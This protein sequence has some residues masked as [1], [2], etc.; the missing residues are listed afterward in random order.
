M[1]TVITLILCAF[2]GELVAQEVEKF[3]NYKWEECKPNEARFYSN[4]QKTDSGYVRKDYFI[5]EKMLQMS[6]KYIDKETKV[7][8]GYFWYF[9]ANGLLDGIGRYEADKKEGLWR[10][11]YSNGMLMDSGFYYKGHVSGTSLSWHQNGYLMDS[12]IANEEGKCLHV[13]W[14]DNG[15]ISSIGYI[16]RGTKKYGT[17]KF[18]HNNGKLSS[19]ETYKNNFLRSKSYFNENGEIIVDTTNHDKDASYIGGIFEWQKYLLKQVY[20]PE[21]HTIVHA[22]KAVVVVSFTINESGKVQDIEVTT[23]FYPEFD[24]IAKRAILNSPTWSPSINHNRKVKVRMQQP[25]VFDQAV[26]RTSK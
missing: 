22:D 20:F 5:H 26:Y 17:W 4:I 21:G 9:H 8:N 19:I 6:G 3:Y 2:Y 14:F 1:K 10:H 24:K 18:Y 15:N 7:R 11:Y 25:I 12:T 16:S 23:P 13:N